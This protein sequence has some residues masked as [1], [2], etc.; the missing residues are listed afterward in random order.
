MT[1]RDDA[2]RWLRRSYWAGAV[3]DALATLT[4]L[5]VGQIREPTAIRPS[6]DV[7]SAELRYGLRC[8]AALMAGWTGLLVWA[9]RA[10]LDRKGVLP[11]T[12]VP[13]IAGLAAADT[14][15]LRAGQLPTARVLPV[16]LLQAS[17]AGVFAYSYAKAA[18]ATRQAR[19]N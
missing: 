15:A 8:A 5:G 2:I 3:V 7:R 6:L 17:L 19:V 14:A 13:V 18:R 11:L 4:W 10:P 16:R 1:T 12:I 9:D